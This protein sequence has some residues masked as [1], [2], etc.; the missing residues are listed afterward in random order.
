LATVSCVSTLIL[1]YS[2]RLKKCLTKPEHFQ[3][4]C[5]GIKAPGLVL[6]IL[7]FSEKNQTPLSK[8]GW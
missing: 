2:K 7:F 5:L 8:P 3:S 4:A 6:V 1:Q